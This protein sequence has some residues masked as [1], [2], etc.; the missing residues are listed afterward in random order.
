MDKL[1][2]VDSTSPSGGEQAVIENVSEKTIPLGKY[3][4]VIDFEDGST[5]QVP[6]NL[7]KSHLLKPSEKILLKTI[8]AP[9]PG[10]SEYAAVIDMPRGFMLGGDPQVRLFPCGGEPVFAVPEPRPAQE[11]R[12]PKTRITNPPPPPKR[13]Q[14]KT[15]GNS[16]LCEK[17]GEPRNVVG[18]CLNRKC[19]GK[20]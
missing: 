20:L 14:K 13:K 10:S 2:M 19:S 11:G 4:L 1:L 6:Q 5:V 8:E 9:S 15:N 18:V 17:C 12:Q 7:L 3:A 16:D